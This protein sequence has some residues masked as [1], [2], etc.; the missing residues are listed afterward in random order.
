M[1]RNYKR[2]AE[3]WMD[4]YKEYIYARR[5]HYKKID[6][7]DLT[8]QKSIRDRLQ[9]KSFKWFMDN[10]AFDLT[11][12]YPP[13]DP[14]D[15]AWGEIRNL[16][17]DKCIDTRFKGHNE[18]FELEP[19]VKDNPKGGG[20]QYFVYTWHKDIRPNKRNK[21]FDVSTSH[22]HSPVVLFPCHSKLLERGSEYST[23][24]ALL[25]FFA[26]YANLL[27]V[28]GMQGNQ[29]WRY[30]LKTKNLFHPISNMCLDCDPGRREI[31]MSACDES[32]QSQKWQFE[33]VNATVV[34]QWQ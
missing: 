6:P 34:E 5:P 3:V 2:V 17:A 30:R 28:L 16:A 12:K 33:K 4:E 9:C 23:A 1:G 32:K 18:R 10:I 11:K 22:D 31:F 13:V 21:C 14:P 20:E 7:G 25:S 27:F 26:C 29:L 15:G 24:G 19:C 8:K